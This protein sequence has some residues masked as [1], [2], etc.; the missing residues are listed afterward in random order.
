[1]GI[2]VVINTY[3]E[4]KNLQEC[5]DSVKGFDEIVVC[6]MESTDET[7]E[8][9]RRNGCKTIIFPKGS[10]TICEPA[11][12]TAIQS[13]SNPWV[14]VLDADEK[15]TPRLRD[16]LYA[17]IENPSD[18]AGLF[19]P[20]KNYVMHRFRKSSYPDS[21][22]RFLKRD[23]SD[24]PVTIH[25]HPTVAGRI[26]RIP[27]KRTDLALIHK[28]VSLTDIVERMNRYTSAQAE[29]KRSK[30]VNL[31][32][33]IFVP[34]WFFFKIY[35]LGGS[36]RYGIAGYIVAKKDAISRFYMLA[37]IYEA[38]NEARFREKERNL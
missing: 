23:G 34:W 18:V 14:L 10:H 12:N 11:R 9:A 31:L 13:A 4:A 19:I 5:L 38:Q 3:N 7:V 21:Q 15:I 2:S 17:F 36:F 35:I 20:R 16:Y 28:S 27:S 8:I 1:M 24:W 32:S 30:K 33:M 22:L 26:D 29:K 37:K 6:D 25:S